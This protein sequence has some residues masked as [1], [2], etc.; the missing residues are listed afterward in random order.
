MSCDISTLD[1]VLMNMLSMMVGLFGGVVGGIKLRQSMLKSRSRDNLSTM[2]HHH[3]TS[4]HPHIHGS[5]MGNQEGGFCSQITG[6]H[7]LPTPVA[8][9]PIATAIPPETT[10]QEIVIRTVD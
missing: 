2:N 8:S 6:T 5:P 4:R 9:A 1:I 7:P 10:K 3:L